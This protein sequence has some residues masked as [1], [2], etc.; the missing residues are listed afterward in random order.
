MKEITIQVDVTLYDNDRNQ[1]RF[2]S[3]PVWIRE[4]ESATRGQCNWVLRQAYNEAMSSKYFDLEIKLVSES[5]TIE[6][7]KAIIRE[8]DFIIL[9]P[10][11][12]K[13]KWSIALSGDNLAEIAEMLTET[14][15][16]A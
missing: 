8:Q 10:Y 3:R 1:T 5:K 7:W 11:G 2:I 15:K 13:Y 14:A 12:S 16:G 6:T 9:T 4:D